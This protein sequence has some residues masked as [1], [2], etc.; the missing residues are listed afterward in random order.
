MTD[1]TPSN[2][3]ERR[4]MDAHYDWLIFADEKEAR[5]LYWQVNNDDI[6]LLRAY[7][8]AQE[9]NGC[10]TM[11]FYED[12]VSKLDYPA[13]L[14]QYIIQF[15]EKR[16]QASLEQG[17]AAN[18]FPPEKIKGST[19]TQYLLQIARS[20]IDYHPDIFPGFLWTFLPENLSSLNKMR[21][22][23]EELIVEVTEGKFADHRIRFVIYTTEENLFADL[24]KNYPH[25]VKHIQGKYFCENVPRELIAESNERG[26]SGRFRRLFVELTE[27]LKNNDPKRLEN[28]SKAAL[29][30]TEKEKWFDQS[31]VVYL[32]AGVAYLKWNDKKQSL[33]AYNDGLNAAHL[34][35]EQA[36][37]AANKLI[38]NTLFGIGSVYFMNKQYE[39]AAKTYDEI[40]PYSLAD[41]DYILAVEGFRMSSM[42]WLKVHESEKAF[43]S[44]LD[45]LD[46]GA[47]MDEDMRKKTTLPLVAHWVYKQVDLWDLRYENVTE[48]LEKLY[49]ENWEKFVQIKPNFEMSEEVV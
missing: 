11:Q 47:L 31:V 33:K 20:L 35:K 21:H 3:V 38:V 24:L 13:R 37:P 45:A 1:F 32:I 48:K 46:V 28:L 15:Y 4:F 25:R 12:F 27:T 23:L 34:A 19:E 5:F 2:P 6:Y 30:I 16:R 14:I 41:D 22:W 39:D 40:P 10:C 17:I 26:P 43:N 18:W 42:C 49:G 7:F 29:K 9:K 8:Q 44:A 36:H